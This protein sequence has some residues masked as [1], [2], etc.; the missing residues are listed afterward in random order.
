MRIPLGV[1]EP[2]KRT[3]QAIAFADFA[4]PPNGGKNPAETFVTLGLCWAQGSSEPGAVTPRS[5]SKAEGGSLIDA[6]ALRN[7]DDASLA[8]GFESNATL[9]GQR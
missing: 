5:S 6:D 1:L 2:L 3:V 4:G 9:A 8:N 7:Q